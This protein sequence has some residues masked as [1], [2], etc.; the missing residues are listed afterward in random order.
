MKSV[1][2]VSFRSKASSIQRDSSLVERAPHSFLRACAALNLS[3]SER[4]LGYDIDEHRDGDMAEDKSG[5]DDILSLEDLMADDPPAAKAVTG[6]P[7]ASIAG[8]PVPPPAP[9]PA[10]EPPKAEPPPPP[11]IKSTSSVSDDFDQL[12]AVADPE[13][14][15]QL[16]DLSELGHEGEAID[17]TDLDNLVD[18]VRIES[19]KTGWRKAIVLL[20]NRPARRIGLQIERLKEFIHWLKTAG[21]PAAVVASRAAVVRAKEVALA[22]VAWLKHHIS[23]FLA[24]P[25]RSKFLIF[26]A[27]VLSAAA[28]FVAKI[29]F[30][31]TLF[32]TLEVP[33]LNSF[34]DVADQA[35]SIGPDEVWDDLNDPLL[36]PEHVVLIERLIANLKN[37]GDGSNPMAL[38]DLYVESASQEVAVEIK[39]RD[40][41]ARDLIGR[42]LGQMTYEDLTTQAGKTKLKVFLR[43]N[44]NEVL[45]TGRVRRVYFRNIIVKP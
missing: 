21:V 27:L 8:A 37:P 43:K 9:A 4:H 39:N 18:R 35:W 17:E 31:G 1:S 42:T 14:A 32:P 25:R 26:A 36:H 7:A 16:N 15:N 11:P 33:Y 3:Y 19:T 45:T 38:I 6:E 22:T 44:L 24:L 41:E 12:L 20:V 23:A 29:T 30:K 13:F 34:A 5:G 40:A 28:V 2:C 10:P